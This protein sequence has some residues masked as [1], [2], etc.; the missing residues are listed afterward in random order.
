LFREFLGAAVDT[1]REGA[2][3]EMPLDDSSDASGDESA[4]ESSEIVERSGI[5]N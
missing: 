1:L 3:H 4:S 2:Q 5:S